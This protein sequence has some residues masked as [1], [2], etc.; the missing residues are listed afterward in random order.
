LNIQLGILRHRILAWR[1]GSQYSL[2][3]SS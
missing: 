1:G 2:D 3:H